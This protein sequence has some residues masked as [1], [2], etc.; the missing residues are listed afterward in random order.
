M[1]F[2]ETAQA[3]IKEHHNRIMTNTPRDLEK[4]ITDALKA[5]YKQGWADYKISVRKRKSTT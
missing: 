3:I 5:A 1:E 4:Q 2:K